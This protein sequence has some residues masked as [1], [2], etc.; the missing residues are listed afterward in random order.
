M[1]T[2]PRLSFTSLLAATPGYLVLL[3]PLVLLVIRSFVVKDFSTGETT[4]SLHWYQKLFEHEAIGAALVSSLWIAIVS[5]GI[6]TLI[7]TLGALALVRSGSFPGKRVLEALIQVP[8]SLPEIVMGLSLLIWFVFLNVTLGVFSVILAHVTFSVSYVALTVRARLQGFDR[9]LEDAARDLGATRFQVFWR[10]TL[11]LILPALVSG[12]LM[13]FTLSFDDFLITYFVSGVGTDTLPLR[14]YS[15]I[16]FGV[17]PELNALS[18]LLLLVTVF[19]AALGLRQV[20]K[21]R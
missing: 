18:T 3:S 1:K 8:L 12:A 5:A 19:F 10:I 21:A 13:A 15:M 7:G 20:A 2:L 11:P 4:W 9:S 17:S 16:R 6:S 14:V